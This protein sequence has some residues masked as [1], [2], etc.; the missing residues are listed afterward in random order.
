MSLSWQS[1]TYACPVCGKKAAKSY[2]G[3][4]PPFVL[5]SNCDCGAQDVGFILI[6]DSEAVTRQTPGNETPPSDLPARE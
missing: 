3:K 5:K 2:W 1:A 6:G 4:W